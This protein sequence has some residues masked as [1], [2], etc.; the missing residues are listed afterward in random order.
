MEGGA[1]WL[2]GGEGRT[3]ALAEMAFMHDMRRISAVDIL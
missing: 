1:L 2:V 3:S